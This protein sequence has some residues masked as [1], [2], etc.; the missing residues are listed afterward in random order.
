MDSTNWDDRYAQA[1]L[2]WSGGPDQ[3][4]AEAACGRSPGRALDLACGEGRNALW[5]ADRDWRVT[6]VDFSAVALA[7]AA[8]MAAGKGQAVT[9]RLEGVQADVLTYDPPPATYDLVL[10]VYLQVPARER[11]QALRSAAAAVA[12]AGTLLVIAHHA[13]NL[14]HGVGGPRDPA[15]LY[16]QQDVVADLAAVAELSIERSELTRR[17]V[18]GAARPS[19]DL[20]VLARRAPVAG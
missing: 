8:E 5:L 12:P 9:A 17:E 16:T 1:P 19:L 14:V 13:D 2:L 18:A 6:G 7:R 15:V 4:V 20:H 3:Q 10:M 11:S